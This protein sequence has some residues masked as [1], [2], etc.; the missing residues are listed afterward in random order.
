MLG[1]PSLDLKIHSLTRAIPSPCRLR[2][3]SV[4]MTRTQAAKRLAVASKA[5]LSHVISPPQVIQ[6]TDHTDFGVENKG[7][8]INEPQGNYIN[9]IGRYHRRLV[10]PI[11]APTQ[12]T[13]DKRGELLRIIAT[14]QSSDV[15]WDAYRMSSALAIDPVEGQKSTIPY[16]YFHRLARLLAST[17]PRTRTLFLRLL[18]V[19]ASLKKAGGTIQGWEWNALIDCAGKGWRKTRPEDYRAALEVYKD[20]TSQK[21]PEGG[22]HDEQDDSE[23]NVS[24]TGVAKPDVVTY[25]TLLYIACRTL[26]P[27]TVRHAGNLLKLSGIHPNQV[28]HL[29]MLRYYT[30]THQISG[31]R[32]TIMRMREQGFELSIDGI[33]ACMTAFMHNSRMDVVSTIYRVLRHHV[34]PE[35]SVGEH[36]I[37]AAIHYLDVTEDIVIAENIIPDRVSYTIIIQGLAYHGD[38]IQA[39]RIFTHMLSSP[40]IEPFAPRVP[41]ENGEL[42]PVNYPT[43]LPVFRALFLGF[44]RHAAPPV[45]KRK[46]EKLSTRLRHLAHPPFSDSPWTLQNLNYLFM[47][48]LELP[49]GTRP[50]ERTIYWILVAFAKTS[51]NNADKLQEVWSQL[52]AHFDGQR[53]GRLEKFRKR[54][55]GE[56]PG[57]DEWEVK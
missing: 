49:M 45:P 17:K 51:G 50:S 5:N 16:A 26:M 55:Y 32:S 20:M 46:E 25:T 23:G 24:E 48:F 15:A 42:L 19:L 41:D 56:S 9:G 21:A 34:V 6:I 40:D 13:T 12:T 4:A 38:L 8:V 14:T 33:N 2:Q 10:E 54:I 7:K 52:E 44:A 53:G 37:R 39:L 47:S 28:T 27:S 3:F 30:R 57:A 22:G 43:T 36:D 29:T 1:A 35:C 31:V 11:H 18:S